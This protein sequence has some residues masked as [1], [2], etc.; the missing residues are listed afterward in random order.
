[1]DDLGKVNWLPPVPK[2]PLPKGADDQTIVITSA[3]PRPEPH[4]YDMAPLVE[5]IHLTTSYEV[6]TPEAFTD[7]LLNRGRYVYQRLW[8][9]TTEAAE[10]TISQLEQ[11]AGSLLYV[12][13]VAALSSLFV[14]VLKPGDHIVAHA[15]CYAGLH[16]ILEHY[17]PRLNMTST[18]VPAGSDTQAFRQACQPNTK[19]FMVESPCNPDT[20]ILDIE[21]LVKVARD[22]NILI[23]L[24]GTFATPILQK[25]IPM[26]VDFS[27]HSCTKYIAGHSDVIAGC[28][29]TRTLEQYQQ[30]KMSQFGFTGTSLG[31]F[32][33]YQVH[34]AMRTLPIRMEKH[35][36]NALAL[37]QALE[38]HPMVNWVRYPGLPSH[39]GHEIA[40][41]QMKSFGGLVAFEVK[42][43]AEGARTFVTSLKVATLTAAIG[44]IKT[45]VNNPYSFS[46]GPLMMNDE[47]RA[48]A[49][50][51]EGLIRLSV[52]LEN[53]DDLIADFNQALDLIVPCTD[54]T[55]PGHASKEFFEQG[56]EVKQKYQRPRGVEDDS[57]YITINYERYYCS[58]FV[59][60][61]L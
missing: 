7:D 1:M 59:P 6:A 9:R 24:D 20:S 37:S 34:H 22:L 35:S 18:Q 57:G 61:A 10:L 3:L 43:N 51:T 11:A 36:A 40:K 49:R 52:G 38:K 55:L 41:K 44:G 29:S 5:P 56:D 48:K 23:C 58:A 25:V 12:S 26:G 60:H 27:L 42:G 54:H 4:S 16:H 17:L 19:L 50:V 46:H 8:N 47:D 14:T 2:R 53:V 33:A 32:E 28:I 21:A 39:P 45:Y 13:G 31:P 30:L 15:P